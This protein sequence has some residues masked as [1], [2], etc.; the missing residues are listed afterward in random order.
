L[1]RTPGNY[2]SLPCTNAASWDQNKANG[3]APQIKGV[4]SFSFEELKKCTNNFSEDNALG[5]G[6]YG[7]V[8]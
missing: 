6:G 1:F 7:T 5:S 2:S 3:A 4:L 8:S